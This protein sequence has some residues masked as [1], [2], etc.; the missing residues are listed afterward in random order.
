MEV[1]CIEQKFLDCYWILNT[2]SPATSLATLE[3]YRMLIY[4]DYYD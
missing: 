2:D 1:T 4:M 3:I